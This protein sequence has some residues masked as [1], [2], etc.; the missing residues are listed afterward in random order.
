MAGAPGC[1]ICPG[2][3]GLRGLAVVGVLLFH[4]GFTWAKGGFLG[5][6]TFFTLSGFL[7]TNLLVREW[8]AS[9]AIRLGRFWVRRF[10]RLLPAALVTIALVGLVWWRIGT[11]E[12]LA[13]LRAD[14]LGA[15]G[16]VAN[17]RFFTAGTSYADL[18]SAPS[19]L[20]HFWS[21]AIE[22]QFYVIFPPVVLVLMHFGGRRLLTA[23]LATATVVSV[24]LE[25]GLGGNIDRVYYGTDTR[26]AELLLGALLAV[27]WS[28]RSSEPSRG[29]HAR[30]DGRTVTRVADVVGIVALLAVFWAWASFDQTSERLAR[31]GFP[32]YALATTAIIYAATRPGLVARLLSIPALRW[33]GLV[34]YGLY[35]YHWPIFLWL[36][37]DR[38]GLSTAPLFA[39]RMGVTIVVAVLS[40]FLIEMPIRRGSMVKTGRSALTAGL[41]G[42]SV[43]ATTAFVITLNP[44]QSQVPYANAQVGEG[45]AS[46]LAPDG[47][48]SSSSLP[49][50]ATTA[51]RVLIVGD[52]GTKDAAPG[53]AAA[54]YGAGATTVIDGAFPGFGL[55]HPEFNPPKGDWRQKY[56]DFVAEN[57]PDLVVMMLGGWDLAY[58]EDNGEEAYTA[59]RRRRRAD[60]HQPWRPPGVDVDDAGR[61]DDRPAGRRRLLS[62]SPTAIPGVVGYADVEPALRVPADAVEIE[63][64]PGVEEWPRWYRTADGTTVVLRKPDGWHMCPEGAARVGAIINQAAADLGWAT[65]APTGTWEQGAWRSDARY[66][67]PP[68]GCTID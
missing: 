15:L 21:L 34:S 28:G 2:L 55:T 5:V 13:G 12:Q 14:M 25:I 49:V 10:R 35:L 22:E 6:S 53:I 67:D 33:A 41:A 23:V 51:E 8:D 48:T 65:I 66:D 29:R 39:V 26:A 17:W 3:D 19:P 40:Y 32:V 60:P 61:Q 50:A 68:G 62:S 58:L 18:F 52:S 59:V 56:T 27:W 16:Y 31:G 36:D 24:A 1:P 42:A 11:P 46:V 30:D 63:A 44:P 37:Q 57:D 64:L 4:G 9:N 45:E 38:T 54:F 43:V 20:Q 47:G 7:I